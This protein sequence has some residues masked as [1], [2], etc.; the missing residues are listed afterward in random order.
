MAPTRIDGL[1]TLWAARDRLRIGGPL[2]GA[3]VQQMARQAGI[4]ASGICQQAVALAERHG[5]A[6]AL[7]R[8]IGRECG[9]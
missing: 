7:I 6:E 8:A 9:R 3:T 1:G 4:T 5:G 2:I